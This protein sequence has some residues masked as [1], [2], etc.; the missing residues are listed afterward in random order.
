[1]AEAE[2]GFQDRR[3]PIT[4][5][6]AAVL[7]ATSVEDRTGKVFGVAKSERRL[8]FVSKTITRIGKLARVVVNKEQ[9]KY[10]SAHDLRRAFGTRWAG[11]VQPATLRELMRHASIE[12]TL[13]YYVGSRGESIAVEL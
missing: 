7:F 3:L 12:T 2:K 10:A 6:F 8:D 4:P 5:D 9:N 13:K 11:R 1:V